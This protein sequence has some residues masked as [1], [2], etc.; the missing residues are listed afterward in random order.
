MTQT[1][2]TNTAMIKRITRCNLPNPTQHTHTYY[3]L[4]PPFQT[5]LTELSGQYKTGACGWLKS[6]GRDAKELPNYKPGDTSTANVTCL[7]RLLYTNTSLSLCACLVTICDKLKVA[8]SHITDRSEQH[9]TDAI[10]TF[11]VQ[12]CFSTRLNL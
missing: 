12:H 1:F 7:L 9:N 6:S 5:F 10:Q 3:P 8:N 11:F 4:F 2:C